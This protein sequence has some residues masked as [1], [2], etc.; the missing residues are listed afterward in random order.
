[1]TAVSSGTHT[2]HIP[3]SKSC[4]CKDVDCTLI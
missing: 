4:I 3:K 2:C 1:M